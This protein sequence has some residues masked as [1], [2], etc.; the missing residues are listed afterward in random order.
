MGRTTTLVVLSL[1]SLQARALMRQQS[2]PAMARPL[3]RSVARMSA[4]TEEVAEAPPP[5]AVP[6]TPAATSTAGAT[7]RGERGWDNE[8]WKAGYTTPRAELSAQLPDVTALPADLQ[9]RFGQ[10]RRGSG[11]N[12]DGGEGEE[13]G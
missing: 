12:V 8:A 6:E 2:G 3:R 10:R 9:V 5:S 7:D 13:R 11:G 1:A 4:A